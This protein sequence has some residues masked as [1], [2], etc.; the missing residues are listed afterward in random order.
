MSE[1]S[2]ITTTLGTTSPEG[3]IGRPNSGVEIAIVGADDRPVARGFVGELVVR[4]P[5]SMLGYI[6]DSSATAEV[7]RG[8]W[9]STGDRARQDHDGYFHLTGRRGLLIN[10]GGLKVAPEEVEAVLAQHPAV[11]EVVVTATPDT[12]RGE[13]VRAIIVPGGATPTIQEL[14][15]FCRA[16]L[17]S[18]KVPRQIEFRQSLPRSALGKVLRHEM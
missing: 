15:R 1:C 17:A 7:M 12:L 9:F 18:H 2:S 16:R 10:V 8:G 14:H 11:R 5:G 3:S 4:S 13:V 6:D